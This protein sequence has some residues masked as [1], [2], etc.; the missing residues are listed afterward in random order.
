MLLN[1]FLI[2]S[3]EGRI[4]TGITMFVATMVLVGWVA[5]NEPARMSAFTDMFTGRSTEK[6]AELF[7]ANCS[8]CHGTDGRGQLGVA[9]ALNNPHLFGFNPFSDIVLDM[10]KIYDQIETLNS[11]RDEL[12]AEIAEGATPER[13]EEITV[14]IGEIDAVLDAEA[15]DG[16]T[17]Q[18]EVLRA[19]RDEIIAQ[20][21]PA[22]GA[23]YLPGLEALLMSPTADA[24][25]FDQA[26]IALINANGTRLGQAQWEGSEDSYIY[27]TLVHGRPGT[28]NV[29][30]GNQMAAWS[31]AAGGPLRDDQLRD[32]TNYIVNWD[33]EW[34][35]EDLLRVKQFSRRKADAAMV[36]SGEAENPAIGDNVD[37]IIT[38]LADVEGD[39]ARGEQIYTGAERTQLR[40]ILGCSGCHAGGAQ[41]PAT[42]STWERV[43]NER[44]TLP[45]F[46][47]YT[48]EQ[49]I[50]ESIVHPNNYIAPGYQ[51][52][53]MPQ[54]YG[55]QLSAQDMADIIAYL[56][57]Y[58]E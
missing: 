4:L 51:S 55:D 7:A 42:D 33:T 17:A 18:L 6:G 44:L 52:G 23:N 43:N 53:V 16:L 11:E 38:M 9:P 56:R 8:S 12:F 31:Q 34:T 27:T 50:V 5:I 3:F 46:A 35:T 49:Y 30:G 40:Q 36:G 45:D 19:E 47:D 13:I 22:L 14:R 10:F 37:D 26:F 58:A 32:L 54:T 20:I 2:G 1:R 28:A 21:E 25:E 57:S 15:E 41:A 29:W 39:A 48:A 24:Q